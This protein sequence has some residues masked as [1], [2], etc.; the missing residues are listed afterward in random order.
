LREIINKPCVNL[1]VA[2]AVDLPQCDLCNIEGKTEMTELE[3]LRAAYHAADDAA[4]AA[5]DAACDAYDA[6]EAERNKTQKEPT[7]D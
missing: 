4:G 1:G 7:N 6:Y 3:K 5:Y 2:F